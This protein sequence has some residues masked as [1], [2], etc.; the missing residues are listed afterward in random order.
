MKHKSF[1]WILATLLSVVLMG[2]SLPRTVFASENYNI[3]VSGTQVTSDNA[4]DVLGDGT[5]YYDDE[6][7]TLTLNNANL[8]GGILI[9]Q[10]NVVNIL[11]QGENKITSNEYGIVKNAY[12]LDPTAPA[13]LFISGPGSLEMQAQTNGIEAYRGLIIENI[14]LVINTQQYSF[15]SHNEGDIVIRNCSKVVATSNEFPTMIGG[16]IEISDC[17]KIETTSNRS[18]GISADRDLTIKNSTVSAMS[19]GQ[20]G[21]YV[22]N[23]FSLT[24]SELFTSSNPSNWAIYT[25]HFNV[26]NSEVTAKG[27][28]KMNSSTGADTSFTMTPTDGKLVELK[29]AKD[30]EGSMT[31]HFSDGIESP[32]DSTVNFS[33]IEQS[34]ISGYNYIHIGEHIHAGGTATCETPAICA[35]C[36]RPY[37][38]PLGHSYGEPAWTWN[39]DGKSATATF[40]CENDATH[41]ETPE[42]KVTSAVKISA[43]CTK[44]G[45]T[46]YTAT[47]TFNGQTYTDTKDVTDIPAAGHKLTKTEAKAATCTEDGNIEYWHCETCDKYFGD[48]KG[49]NEIPLDSTKIQKTGHKYGEPVWKWSEDS[50]KATATFTCQNDNSHQVT[51]S[52]TVE[53]TVKSEPICTEPGVT[54]YTATVTFNGQKYTTVTEAADIPAV[55]HK[56]TKTEAKE[57]TCAEEGNIEYWACST[58]GKYFSDSEGKKEI[59]LSDTKLEAKGHA[60]KEGKCTECGAIDPNYKVMITAGANSTWQKGSKSDLSFTSNASYDYFQKVLVDGKE[61]NSSN[62]TVKEGSTIVTLNT[63]YLETLSVGKYKLDIVSEIGTASTEFTV[64]AAATDNNTNALQTGNYNSFVPWIIV[65]VV[66]CA[67]IVGIV[68]YNKKKNG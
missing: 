49:E 66:A 46:T 42:V 57:P 6:T 33:E 32:Y 61:I 39:E 12:P 47:V 48:D 24:N 40:T 17:D 58:C 60:Y 2:W 19:V 8:N 36:G 44:A 51:E 43:T 45:V 20:A 25:E 23:T 9:S 54:T 5:V 59:K 21:I 30:M 64:K 37:G 1:N 38:N 28:L 16:K 11:I 65:I 3:T 63:A 15:V 68:L 4:S 41:K 50:Q 22:A 27:G 67:A 55:G 13:G 62:Y 10:E 31:K 52:A 53:T 7:K 34:A 18:Q 26:I 56:L 29:V 35:D 14:D